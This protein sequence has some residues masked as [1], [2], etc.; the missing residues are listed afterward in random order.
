MH[1]VTR[2]LLAGVLVTAVGV[3]ITSAAQHITIQ[4]PADNPDSALQPGPGVDTVR[5]R[6]AICHSTD[7]IVRQPHL[8]AKHWSDEVNK[9]IHVYG[10]PITESDA[11][12][13]AE[14]LGKNYGT[15]ETRNDQR[16]VEGNP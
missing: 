14:Y 3:L 12:S 9:M 6:C 2:H 5:S 11:K 13:I 4:L 10:A 8:D 15:Q 7:Y 1:N 16:S